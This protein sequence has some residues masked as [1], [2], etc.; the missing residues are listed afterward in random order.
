MP[1]GQARLFIFKEWSRTWAKHRRK[2]IADRDD[3]V[4]T[5]LLDG[6]VFNLQALQKLLGQTEESAK[7]WAT[8]YGVPALKGKSW[9]FSGRLLREAL[10]PAM[11]E[12]L[13]KQSDRAAL[14][15]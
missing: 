8:R 1:R 15:T 12:Q 13:K 9:L 4:A 7:K 10:E 5:V 6:S 14:K 2:C 3:I 11:L